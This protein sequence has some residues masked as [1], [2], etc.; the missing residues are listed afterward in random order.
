MCS[1]IMPSWQ[2]LPL[3]SSLYGKDTDDLLLTQD[4]FTLAQVLVSLL[5]SIVLLGNLAYVALLF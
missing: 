1:V 5:P 2:I 4:I 3:G